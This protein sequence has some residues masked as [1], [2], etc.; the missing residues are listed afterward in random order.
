MVR[1]A[2]LTVMLGALRLFAAED[3][4][5]FATVDL[6]SATPNGA[7]CPFGWMIWLTNSFWVDDGHVTVERVCQNWTQPAKHAEELFIIGTNQKVVS[8]KIDSKF[9]ITRG[10]I[11]TLLVHRE[12]DVEILDSSLQTVQ[13]LSCPSQ[14]ERCHVFLPPSTSQTDFAICSMARTIGT[15]TFYAG[16]P[17]TA[18]ETVQ[19]PGGFEKRPY[20]EPTLPRLSS[21]AIT[22]NPISVGRETWFFTQNDSLMAVLPDG[23]I[24]PVSNTHWVPDGSYCHGEVSIAE[25]RRFLATC[26]GAY[27]YTDGDLDNLFGYSRIALFDVATRRIILHVS[28][29]AYTSAALSPSGQL[30][31]IAHGNKVRMYRIP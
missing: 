21:G 12:H 6:N 4:K 20:E 27:V 9:A 24:G 22:L 17:A 3:A 25:P 15:C 13:T 30:V 31:A 10:H 29:R 7:K 2:L 26:D 11:G 16:R 28:G 14:Q 5:P 1:V 23:T 18:I 19:L 8:I